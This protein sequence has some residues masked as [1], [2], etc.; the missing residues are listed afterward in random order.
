MEDD[1]PYL[2]EGRSNVV[3]ALCC[4]T[5]HDKEVLPKQSGGMPDQRDTSN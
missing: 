5:E 2:L 1:G 3:D 4:A